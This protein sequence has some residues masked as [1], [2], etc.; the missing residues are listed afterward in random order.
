MTTLVTT[1]HPELKAYSHERYGV[2]NA[3]V[4]FDLQTLAP[5]YRLIIGLPGRSNALAIATRLGLPAHIIA[6]ARQMV[7]TDDLIAE[8][9]LDE[10]QKTREETR[11]SRDAALQ[12]QNRVEDLERDLRLKQADMEHERKDILGEARRVADREL[13]EVQTEIR[14]LKGAL[15]A[16]GQPLEAIKQVELGMANLK[17]NMAAPVG[18]QAAPVDVDDRPTFRLGET[19]WVSPLRAEGEITELSASDAEVAIGRLRVRAKLDEI[20]KRA[21]SEMVS[22]KRGSRD[23]NYS[24]TRSDSRSEFA[25]RVGYAHLTRCFTRVRA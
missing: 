24:P 17:E 18:G 21:K 8:D 25:G 5:T 2:R 14:H 12:A 7:G 22:R 20:T 6:D 4:E 23:P 13:A 10:L 11:R 15:R 9:L 16:A 3:S 19:V 1:H